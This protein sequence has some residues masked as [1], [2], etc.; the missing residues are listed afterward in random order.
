MTS[1]MAKPM[2]KPMRSGLGAALKK[3]DTASSQ[4]YTTTQGPSIRKKY[5]P[6]APGKK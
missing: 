1:K 2:K 6:A 5:P 3:A 4:P